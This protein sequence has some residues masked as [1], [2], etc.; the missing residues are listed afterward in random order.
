MIVAFRRHT[1]LP[2][3]DCLYA[4]HG[5]VPMLRSVLTCNERLRPIWPCCRQDEPL[6]GFQKWG[7]FHDV[8]Q[9]AATTSSV[10]LGRIVRS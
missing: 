4:L 3:D 2:L 7:G 9:A 1:L 6:V 10:D 8:T 5:T